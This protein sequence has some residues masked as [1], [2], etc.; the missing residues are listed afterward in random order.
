MG[1]AC[2]HDGCVQFVAELRRVVGGLVT[3]LGIVKGALYYEKVRR[4]MVRR[5]MVRRGMAWR[6]VAGQRVRLQ[7]YRLPVHL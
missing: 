5:G 7:K 1:M 3:K 2:G 6:A 4:G